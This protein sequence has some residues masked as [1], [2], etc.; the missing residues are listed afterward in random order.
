[1]GQHYALDGMLL[2]S[3]KKCNNISAISFEDINEQPKLVTFANN[4]L[5]C[6]NIPLQIGDSSSKV[7]LSLGIPFKTDLILENIVR[8]YYLLN[9]NELLCIGIDKKYGV[10]SFELI[11]DPEIVQNRLNFIN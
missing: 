7:I 11:L 2:C 1:M 9:I 6:L 5:K 3:L 10:V 4:V 8:F